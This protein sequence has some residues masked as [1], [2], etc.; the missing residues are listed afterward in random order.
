[1]N[2]VIRSGGLAPVDKAALTPCIGTPEHKDN[3]LALVRDGLDDRVGEV[4][5]AEA[6]V[7]RRLVLQYGEDCIEEE[8]ALPCPVGEV[9]RG[10]LDA[11]VV[12]Y[13]L[14]DVEERGWWRCTLGDGEAESVGLT[15]VVVGVLTEDNDL[16]LVERCLVEGTE[17][18]AWRRI[19]CFTLIEIVGPYPLGKGLKLGGREVVSERRLPTLVYLHLHSGSIPDR[20][21]MEE[22]LVMEIKGHR[23]TQKGWGELLEGLVKI[24]RAAHE[25]GREVRLRPIRNPRGWYL[26]VT[27]GGDNKAVAL[28]ALARAD[29]FGVCVADW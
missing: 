25:C 27:Q 15:G 24:V 11:E 28:E 9:S 3:V 21:G 7:A 13:L 10:T 23:P 19:H 14:K 29:E 17:E 26:L 20:V 6:G 22:D 8:D 18:V 5:P 12:L 16:Y 4:L 2:G 1:M